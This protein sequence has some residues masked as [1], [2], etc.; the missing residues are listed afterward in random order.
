MNKE[1]NVCTD[2]EDTRENNVST[3]TWI[4]EHFVYLF[5]AHYKVV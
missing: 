2:T 4:S 1:Q 3:D 5:V